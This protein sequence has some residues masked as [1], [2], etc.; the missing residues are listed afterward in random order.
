MKVG[1][2]RSYRLPES[3]IAISAGHRVHEDPNV[4]G[5]FPEGLGYQPDLWLLTGEPE[6]QIERIAAC[7]SDSS[8]AE[9]LDAALP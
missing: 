6:E 7:L 4:D 8:C 3:R 9:G 5:I 2:L 1:E